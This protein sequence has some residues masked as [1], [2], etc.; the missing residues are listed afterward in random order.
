MGK[1]GDLWVRLGLKKQDFDKGI[2]QA[3]KR[4]GG[5]GKA[6][7]VLKNVAI[8]AF[9]AIVTAAAGMF[10]DI[11]QKSQRL[12]DAWTKVTNEMSTAWNVFLSS[13]ASWDWDSFGD[14]IRNAMSASRSNTQAWDELT[15]VQNANKIK[16]AAMQDELAQLQILARDTSKSQEERAAAAKRY[17]ELVKPLYDAEIAATEKIRKSEENLYL[18]QANVENNGAN[19]KNLEK[20]LTDIAVDNTSMDALLKKAQELKGEVVSYSMEEVKALENIANDRGFEGNAIEALANI[21]NF[22]QNKANDLDTA[23]IV[24]AIQQAGNA[25]SGLNDETRRL[26]NV[27]KTTGGGNSG[28]SSA[29]KAGRD[30]A[31]RIQKQAEDSLKSEET[32]LREHYEEDLKL[33]NKYHMDSE[34]RTKQYENDMLALVLE[35]IEDIDDELEEIVDEPIEVPPVDTTNLKKLL[36]DYK[37]GI[38][39]AQALKDE[40]IDAVVGGFSDGVQELTDQFMGLSEINPG[41]IIQALLT[42]LADMAIREGEILIAQGLGVEAVKKSLA[43]LDGTTAII[44]GA[45]LLTIGAATK[46]GLAALAQGGSGTTVQSYGGGASNGMGDVIR[47]ELVVKV[48]GTIKG[49]DIV[50]SG[51]KTEQY[52]GR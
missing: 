41:R 10:D 28:A 19:R 16:R 6:F 1:I 51:Q 8:G 21:A 4:L 44:A 22:Y 31:K 36:D 40:F 29:W 24:E 3:E 38:Q 35:G 45:A 49:S 25:A 52:W 9:A 23:R 11:I 47:S 13:L 48:E 50:L 42:P 15:E 14:R 32:L 27:G 2:D 20:F 43:A 39:R 18:S 5:F 30:N 17:W 34:A 7:T 26:Q 37:E 33:L 12:G 46:S